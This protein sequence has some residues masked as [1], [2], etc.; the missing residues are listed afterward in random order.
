MTAKIL[1]F[2][3][4]IIKNGYKIS[5]YTDEEIFLTVSVVNIF[6][7]SKIK[8][9]KNNIANY[10]PNIILSCLDKAIASDI[11]SQKTK[12]IINRI[13]RSAEKIEIRI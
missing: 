12:V 4:P 9:D 5:L 8:A 2:P 1:K 10:D 3:E 13:I 7:S 11:F 6:S